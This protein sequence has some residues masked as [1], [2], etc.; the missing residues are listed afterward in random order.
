[1]INSGVG[2]LSYLMTKLQ[3]YL[4]PYSYSFFKSDKSGKKKIK[5]EKKSLS[6]YF[7]FAF[8]LL[9]K[10]ATFITSRVDHIMFALRSTLTF[11]MGGWG[12]K[13]LGYD[14]AS[15]SIIIF[16]FHHLQPIPY[17]FLP[18]TPYNYNYVTNMLHVTQKKSIRN[19]TLFLVLIFKPF[20]TVT[21]M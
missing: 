13:K 12:L 2:S 16:H 5:Q 10:Y 17:A 14:I 11:P 6:S 19:V 4:Q 15:F 20:F 21:N 3:F 8:F 1:M 7:F 9:E 18:I